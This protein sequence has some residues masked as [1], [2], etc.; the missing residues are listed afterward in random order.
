MKVFIVDDSK[1]LLFLL[2]SMLKRAGY[3]VTS[4]RD[5]K[6]ALE[7]LKRDSSVDLIVSDILMPVMDGFQFCRECKKD[8]ALKNIPF[9]FYTATYLEKGDEEFGLGLGAVRFIMKPMEREYFLEIIKD[10]L[11]EHKRGLLPPSVKP[12]EKEEP[13]FLKE[14]NERLVTKLENKL[15][16]LE[17]ANHTLRESEEELRKRSHDL[18]ERIKEL[19]CLYAISNLVEKPDIS[20]EALIQGIVNL[21]PP[22]LAVS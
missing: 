5:G 22:C 10:V 4:A 9:I 2:E 6:E 19:S 14:Y 16:E 20:Y 15:V 1:E 21:M 3:E 17:S 12:A 13:I 11:E 7:G 8:E 18:E